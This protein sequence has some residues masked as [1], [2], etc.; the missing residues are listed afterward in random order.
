[1][2]LFEKNIKKYWIRI[3]LVCLSWIFMIAA[4][5]VY[6]GLSLS[7]ALTES[8]LQGSSILVGGWLLGN[9]FNYY[10]PQKG[11]IWIAIAMPLIFS[12]GMTY[13]HYWVVTLLW[14][15]SAAYYDFVQKASVL[16]GFYFYM[17][18]QFW[19]ILL[20]LMGKL[21]DQQKV[22]ERELHSDKLAKEA[23]MYHLRQ[24]LQPHF[25][26]N[27]LNSISALV[28]SQPDKAREMTVELADFL[29]GTIRKDVHQWVDLEEEISQIHKFLY[30][31][32]VRFGDR[33]NVSIQI[34]EEAKHG[35]IPQLML[36]PLL[37]NAIKHGLYGLTG[38]VQIQIQITIKDANLTISIENPY[39]PKAG[40]PKGSGF[41]LEAV[42]RRLELLF[43]RADL[44]KVVQNK[45]HFLVNLT[46]PQ[47]A[48]KNPYH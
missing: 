11:Q 14:K 22:K 47:Y 27:S 41:G 16:K 34:D 32:K 30:I 38:E 13:L 5:L 37:E 46:I 45:E 19:T 42:R 24:Q 26:F 18:F 17:L 36:Q 2:P 31:E 9:V 29:R 25:L 40:Q 20:I 33:L 4:I 21:E 39:D 28:K 12:A 7:T 35:Q 6:Y 10:N 23:E 8:M 43:G 3:L 1:M 48:T 15:E 44:I